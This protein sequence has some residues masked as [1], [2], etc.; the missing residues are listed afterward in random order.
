MWRT[1]W[2]CPKSLS[3]DR[4]QYSRRAVDGYR[5]KTG[6]NALFENEG[7]ITLN[8]VMVV[9]SYLAEMLGLVIRFEPEIDEFGRSRASK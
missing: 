6:A 4:G 5:F 9:C 7:H 1:R 8:G 2:V 3:A